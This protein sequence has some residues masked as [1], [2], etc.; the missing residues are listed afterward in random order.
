MTDSGNNARTVNLIGYSEGEVA[1][2]KLNFFA[3]TYYNTSTR[4][5]AGNAAAAGKALMTIANYVNYF[6]AE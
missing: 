3:N 5:L 2:G 6:V 4:A 1:A